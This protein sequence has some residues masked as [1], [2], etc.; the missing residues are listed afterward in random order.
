MNKET[1]KILE[2]LELLL[3]SCPCI[4]IPG[5]ED[6]GYIYP[7]VWEKSKQGEFN[8]LNLSL[9]KGWLQPTDHDAI[10]TS[11]QAIEYAK[12]FNSFSLN[13]DEFS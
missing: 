11:S 3:E 6:G 10:R 4:N 8:A 9:S 1:N 13:E 5:H 2:T 7:F 12:S